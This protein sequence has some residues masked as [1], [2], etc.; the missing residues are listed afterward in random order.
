MQEGDW[1]SDVAR[2]LE[3]KYPEQVKAV[4]INHVNLV[5]APFFTHKS[6]SGGISYL[7]PCRSLCLN[8]NS[9]TQLHRLRKEVYQA[10]QAIHKCRTRLLYGPGLNAKDFGIRNA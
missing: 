8:R 10:T 9:I 6:G 5:S 4:H 2:N 1:G 7:D 3:K